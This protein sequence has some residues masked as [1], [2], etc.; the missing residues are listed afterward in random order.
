PELHKMLELGVKG[1]QF[2]SGAQKDGFLKYDGGRPV[3]AYDYETKRYVEYAEIH[4]KCDE[5]IGVIPT[6]LKPWKAVNF[7]KKKF[8][9]LDGYFKE[10]NETDSFG[11]KLAIEYLNNSKEIGKKLVNMNVA[12]TDEDV[13]TVLLTGF[14][15]AYGPINNY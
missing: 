1:G 7:N 15:H 8:D 12:R 13:N 11:G 10:L 3:A 4:T 5:K 14:Y 9:I 6:S 2:S